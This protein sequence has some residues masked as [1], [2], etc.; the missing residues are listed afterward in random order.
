M[1]EAEMAPLALELRHNGRMPD[2]HREREI[3]MQINLEHGIFL[4]LCRLSRP[5]FRKRAHDQHGTPGGFHL[6]LAYTL[7]YYAQ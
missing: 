7:I 6:C 1:A 2:S 3:G 4:C 5:F